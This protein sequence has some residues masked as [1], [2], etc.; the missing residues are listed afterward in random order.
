M[1]TG[2]KIHE[3]ASNREPTTYLS[4]FPQ[5]LEDVGARILDGLMRII[6]RED[7]QFDVAVRRPGV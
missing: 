6:G 4:E 1:D 3:T 7:Y 2:R 5:C